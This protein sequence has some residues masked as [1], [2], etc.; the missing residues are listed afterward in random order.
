MIIVINWIC[1]QWLEF[2]EDKTIGQ[3]LSACSFVCHAWRNQVRHNFHNHARIC[4]E[5]LSSLSNALR[6][7]VLLSLHIA[8]ISITRKCKVFPISPFAVIHRLPR[9]GYLSIDQLDLAREHRWLNRA[10][11]FHSVRALHLSFHQSCQLSQLIRFINA[12]SSLSSLEISFASHAPYEL[13]HNG[14]ILCKPSYINMRSLNQLR[15]D[16]IPGT[17]KLIDWFFQ[18]RPLLACLKIVILYLSNLR[19]EPEFR[20]GFEGVRRILAC[21]RASV[22]DIRL[23][24]DVAPRTETA[25]ESAS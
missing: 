20:L 8:G 15:L 11:L 12:F 16:L 14:Q 10:P 7:N 21:C 6:S 17:S 25:F 5:Q 1:H 23:Y 18:A 3:V 22:E 2:T 24:V 13:E 19:Y 4:Y 9:L